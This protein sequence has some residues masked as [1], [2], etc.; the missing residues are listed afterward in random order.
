MIYIH[1]KSGTIPAILTLL[2]LFACEKS[3][4]NEKFECSFVSP[5]PNEILANETQIQL[6]ITASHDVYSVTFFFDDVCIGQ[7]KM[8]PHSVQWT[9]LGRAGGSHILKAVVVPYEF[10]NVTLTVPVLFKYYPGENAQGGTV[11]SVDET[12]LHGHVVATA[13]LQFNNKNDLAWGIEEFMGA[14]DSTDGQSNTELLANAGLLTNYFWTAFKLGYNHNGYTDW[15]VPSKTEMLQLLDYLT[16]ALS[17][18]TMS[19]TYWTSTE[20]CRANAC[21]VDFAEKKAIVT[22]KADSLFR[23]RPIR[24]F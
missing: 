1:L 7:S 3:N 8:S 24:K 19:D 14:T 11:W 20:C 15:F 9:P 13:D 21:A 2:V 5:V 6:T 4:R 18:A 23:I 12:G 10:E 17:P 16:G 22:L